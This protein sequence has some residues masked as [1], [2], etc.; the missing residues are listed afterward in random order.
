MKA[1][2]NPMSAAA[3]VV[4]VVEQELKAPGAGAGAFGQWAL[5]LAGARRNA[6]AGREADKAAEKNVA[7]DEAAD[8]G[9]CVGGEDA[10]LAVREG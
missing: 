3:G 4:Q 10:G 7:V 6:R 2:T 5:A 9:G 1:E 8:A